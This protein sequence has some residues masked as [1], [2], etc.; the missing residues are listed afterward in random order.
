[1]ATR[2]HGAVRF[3]VKAGKRAAIGTLKEI[4]KSVAGEAGT[5]VYPE[6]SFT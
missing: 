3:V 4:D 5:N 2:V 6:K 1:M